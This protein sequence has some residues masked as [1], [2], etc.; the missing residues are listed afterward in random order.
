[1]YKYLV[2]TLIGPDR[3]G[4]VDRITERV[5]D[6]DGN[7]EES[8]MARLGGEFAMLLFISAPTQKIEKL[9]TALSD[10]E[11]EG[12]QVFSRQTEPE[13]TMQY[14]GRL[15]YRVSV[16]GAD[17]EGIV[18]SITHHLAEQNI[19][20]EIMDTNTAAAPMSGTLLFTMTAIVVVPAELNFHSWRDR[21]DEIG[22]TLNVTIDVAP[23][24][25]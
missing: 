6:Y 15:P 17:H 11:S 5:L 9:N 12:F 13:K 22:D 21:L 18:H 7:V 3:V 14:E 25:G 23:Y 24:T 19:N 4:I 1:M 10:L 20:V 8:R 16:T 2:M